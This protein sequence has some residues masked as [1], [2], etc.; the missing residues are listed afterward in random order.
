MKVTP[1]V[2][3]PV[4]FILNVLERSDLRLRFLEV[5]PAGVVRIE[6]LDRRA[7]H[8]ALLKILVVIEV[9]VVG[10]D[11]VEVTHVDG[12]RRLLLRQERL[13]HLLA[14]ADADDLDVL[15]LAA[16][17]LAHGLGLRLDRAGEGLLD[18][19]VAI[20]SMLERKE[21]QVDSLLQRHDEPRHL[22]LGERD[23]IPLPDL[24][25]PQ[26]NHGAAGAHHVA[27]AGAAD[28][29]ITAEAALR[30]EIPA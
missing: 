9:A 25:D 3:N 30:L 17:E 19:D 5:Q 26:R 6:L 14:M 8:I 12:L 13:V 2:R 22:G 10:G 23:R 4:E 21:H 20:P 18:Q 28:L 29:R 11:S 16:E 24:V 1:D 27:V 7:L 15:L